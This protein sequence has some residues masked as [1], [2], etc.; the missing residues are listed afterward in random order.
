MSLNT[1]DRFPE[2]S[3]KTLTADGMQDVSSKELCDGKTVVLFAVPG[4]FTP[5]CSDVHLPGFVEHLDD[6]KAK[7]ADTVACLAVNDAFVLGAWKKQ[8]GIP[9]DILLLS[10]GN[11]DFSHSTGLEMDISAFGMGK[12]AKRYAMIVRD[13]EVTYLGVEPGREVGVSSAQ[14]VLE[15]L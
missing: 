12:R 14:A 9:D 6:L 3:F 4:A 1:G 11:G 2:A 5:T 10:D 15:N 8:R 7:G 13:G